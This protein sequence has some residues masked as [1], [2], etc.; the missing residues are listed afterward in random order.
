[1]KI[2]GTDNDIL[3]WE[4]LQ[5]FRTSRCLSPMGQLMISLLHDAGEL[6]S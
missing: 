3:T 2:I 4:D 1:M 5:I 6:K